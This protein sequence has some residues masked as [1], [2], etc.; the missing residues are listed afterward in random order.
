MS[1]G[2]ARGTP[3]ARCLE[4]YPSAQSTPSSALNSVAVKFISG[5]DLIRGYDHMFNRFAGR[6]KFSEAVSVLGA[7]MNDRY[8]VTENDHAA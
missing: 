8:T 5:W 7:T 2:M 6:F 4:A 1:F 3:E